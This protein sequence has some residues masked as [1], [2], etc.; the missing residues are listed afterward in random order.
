MV[1]RLLIAYGNA[2]THVATTR[3]YLE[4]FFNYSQFDV[5]FVNVTHG[6]ELRFDLDEFDVVLNNYCA[7]LCFEGFV[8]PSYTEALKRFSGLRVLAI[9]D[10]YDR[11]DILRRSIDELGFQLLLTCVPQV[12]LE[13]VYPSA[14]FPHT[15]FLTVLTGYVPEAPGLARVHRIPLAERPI[16]VGYRGGYI[17]ERYGRLAFDKFEIGRRMREICQARGVAHNIEWEGNTRIYGNA[18]Y[19]F[20]G[21][22]RATLGSESGSNVFDLD[23]S[24]QRAAVA[25]STG[26]PAEVERFHALIEAR[27]KEINMGQISP[28]IFEAA[29]LRTP[30]ILFEGRYSDAVRPREHYIELKKDFSNIDDVLRQ[31]EDIQ[32]LEAMA[33]RA[34]DHLVGS[35]QF[36]YRCF[37]QRVEAAMLKRLQVLGRAGVMRSTAF[38]PR[39]ERLDGL[40]AEGDILGEYPTVHPKTIDHFFFKQQCLQANAYRAERDAYRGQVERLTERLKEVE[41]LVGRPGIALLWRTHQLVFA[42]ARRLWRALPLGLRSRLRGRVRQLR[43]IFQRPAE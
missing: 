37:V 41:R 17:G 39:S 31:L 32:A 5:R 43:Q 4:S 12:S 38:P 24:I 20:L 2:S 19:E 25:A 33:N 35:G 27:E 3:E 18:W 8:S 30:M 34:Y 10:E 22:C 9:Q 28:R 14:S 29:I 16:T 36:S 23:G 21:S 7:R 26:G 6:A 13:Y 1:G 42:I 15:E 11:T 40:Y